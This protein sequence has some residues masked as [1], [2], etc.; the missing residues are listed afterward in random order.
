VAGLEK[1]LRH[2]SAHDPETNESD[3]GHGSLLRYERR[4]CGSL[5]KND[6]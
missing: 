6:P 5:M 4:S 1:I 3:A 2:G